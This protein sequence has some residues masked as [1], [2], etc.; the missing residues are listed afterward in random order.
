[1]NSKPNIRDI[2]ES[3]VQHWDSDLACVERVSSFAANCTDGSLQHACDMIHELSKCDLDQAWRHWAQSLE[4]SKLTVNHQT[5]LDLFPQLPTALDYEEMRCAQCRTPDKLLELVHCEAQARSRWGDAIGPLYYREK[6]GAEIEPS[7][8][9]TRTLTIKFAPQ[10]GRS[11]PDIITPL[12]GTIHVGRSSQPTQCIGA[13]EDATGISL[14]IAEPHERQ[15][16]RTQLR[17]QL[18]TPNYALIFNSATTE[19]H[20]GTRVDQLPAGQFRLVSFPFMVKLPGV[21]LIAS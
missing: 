7:E 15:I 20:F 14:V 12:R 6:Y 16:S 1:M 21:K 18:L 17:I 3:F 2:C 19:S 13:C 5:I 8:V 9:K 11:R 10:L 4:H